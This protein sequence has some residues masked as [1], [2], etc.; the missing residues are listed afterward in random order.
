MQ[1]DEF[2]EEICPIIAHDA[3][4]FSEICSALAD[5]KHIADAV[6]NPLPKTIS[7]RGWL[8]LGFL[9]LVLIVASLFLCSCN[10]SGE[11]E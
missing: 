7:I 1:L 11:K 4:K 8:I 3:S 2:D 6:P 9:V 5:P 10:N